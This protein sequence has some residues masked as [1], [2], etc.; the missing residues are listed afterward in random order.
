MKITDKTVSDCQKFRE[1]IE[2]QIEE[3]EKKTGGQIVSIGLA[4]C[5]DLTI[6]Q[7][8]VEFD[9]IVVKAGGRL[10]F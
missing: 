6:Y 1:V 9:R 4:H 10:P 8:D 5:P 3:F 7:F 2:T